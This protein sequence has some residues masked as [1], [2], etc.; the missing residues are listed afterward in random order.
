MCLSALWLRVRALCSV[1]SLLYSALGR[2]LGVTHYLAVRRAEEAGVSPLAFLSESLLIS[3]F[4]ASAAQFSH[5]RSD[6]FC[7][8]TNSRGWETADRMQSCSEYFW[9]PNNPG[10]IDSFRLLWSLQSSLILSW[11]VTQTA[12]TYKKPNLLM[13]S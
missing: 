10:C 6:P 2:P 7:F 11:G 3:C 8:T 4:C 1:G 5:I 9:A 13:C 12:N